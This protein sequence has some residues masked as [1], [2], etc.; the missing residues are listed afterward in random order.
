M[1]HAN[2]GA[3]LNGFPDNKSIIGKIRSR[4]GNYFEW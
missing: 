2:G 1:G 4:T 3:I